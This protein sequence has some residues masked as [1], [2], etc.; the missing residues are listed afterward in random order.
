MME[1]NLCWLHISHFQ[2]PPERNPTKSRAWP[3]NLKSLQNEIDSIFFQPTAKKAPKS[4]STELRTG[5]M[6]QDNWVGNLQEFTLSLSLPLSKNI[7]IQF[8]FS[9]DF[10]IL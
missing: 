4:S 8:S 5:M 7:C 1:V 6:C 3:W 2:A 9:D 10:A